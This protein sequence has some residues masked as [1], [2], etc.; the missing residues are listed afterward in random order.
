M[1]MS[2]EEFHNLYEITLVLLNM[3]FPVVDPRFTRRG[4]QTQR[5]VPTY[6]LGKYSR[7]LHEIKENG[8]GG[9]IISVYMATYPWNFNSS[10]F[11]A[12]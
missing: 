11:V 6:Y 3:L 9:I 5:G 12:V 7:K 10:E 8:V 1:S 2:S 4:R